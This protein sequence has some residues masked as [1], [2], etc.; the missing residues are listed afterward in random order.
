[1]TVGGFEKPGS[2]LGGGCVYRPTGTFLGKAKTIE[3]MD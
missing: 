1:M 2:V 3:Q